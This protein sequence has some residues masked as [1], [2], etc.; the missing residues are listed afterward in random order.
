MILCAYLTFYLNYTQRFHTATTPGVS[1]IRLFSVRRD[2]L[3]VYLEKRFSD[4][5]ERPPPQGALLVLW[6]GGRVDRMTDIFIF[7]E[8]W[9]KL[10]Y[11]FL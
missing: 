6:G 8:M 5:G 3:A 2:L 10:K 7:N 11:I 1:S 4:C 9:C